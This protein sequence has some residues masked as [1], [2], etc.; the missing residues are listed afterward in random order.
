MATLYPIVTVS[1]LH[2]LVPVRYIPSGLWVLLFGVIIYPNVFLRKL[3]YISYMSTL[4]VV[5]AGVV[6]ATIVL[7]CFTS[8]SS[9]HMGQMVILEPKEFIAA[10]GVVV[11]S[12][13]SQM[14]LSVIEN[15]MRNREMVGTVMNFGYAAMTL[16]KIGIGVVAYL[17]FG[18]DTSQV[19]TLN[20]PPG[21]LLTAVNFIVLLMALSSYT[22]PMFTV[23]EILENDSPLFA[24]AENEKSKS[25]SELF[26]ETVR[27]VGIRS[28][29]VLIT[30]VM[31]ISVPHFCLF[32][33]FIGC[34]TGCFLEMVFP[35][36]FYVILKFEK[37]STGEV[38]FN[39]F[40]IVASLL[41]MG[42]GMYFSGLA[43]VKAFRLHTK[44]VWTV[45]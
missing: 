4:T 14:Y 33:S 38:L 21:I 16:F 17:T 39:V 9:W 12:Y 7:Y 41:F 42:V 10:I 44:E 34:F 40:V 19:V 31:A 6:T 43:I 25:T 23:F 11:A 8:V 30:L 5:S 1:V 29:L 13:S 15:S 26:M 18:A 20:L 27:R 22:L 45:E 37:L 35:C 2:T 24:K 3:Y 32:L 28:V 36:A